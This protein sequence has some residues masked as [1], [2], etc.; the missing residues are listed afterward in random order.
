MDLRAGCGT[1]RTMRWLIVAMLALFVT[2]SD[3]DAQAFKPRG[4]SKAPA[5]APAK[6]AT[7]AK[8]SAA[9]KKAGKP[10]KKTSRAAQSSARPDDL[11]PDENAPSKKSAKE[12]SPEDEDDYVLIEDD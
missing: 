2:G 4:G 7:P 5:K 10:A 9:P 6:K 3:A 8:K 1:I 12:S 11:T